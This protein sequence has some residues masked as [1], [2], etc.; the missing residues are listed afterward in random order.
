M[1]EN[2]YSS[3][4]QSVRIDS[5]VSNQTQ[6]Y[7][8]L[9][10]AR[11]VFLAWEKLRIAYIAILGMVTLLLVG[12]MG[13]TSFRILTL[14]IEGAVVANLAYFLGPA[15]ETYI[16]WLGYDRA[17]PRW[18][19]FFCGTLLSILLAVGSLAAYLLPN[20]N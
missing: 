13:F 3:T 2:P 4:L 8:L 6:D 7:D 14:V 15:T 11:K 16:R 10:I 18:A 20:Q 12:P 1:S 17:W 5:P 19:M 9:T